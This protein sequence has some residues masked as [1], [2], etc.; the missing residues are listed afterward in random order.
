MHLDM[1]A[2]DH[3]H[4]PPRLPKDAANGTCPA[5][6]M[7]LSVLG[8][9]LRKQSL[10][11]FGPRADRTEA[12]E[13]TTPAAAAPQTHPPLATASGTQ[14][15]PAPSRRAST[16]SGTST[17][18]TKK[19]KR[20]KTIYKLAQPP[21]PRGKL[22]R[23]KVV[24]QLHQVVASRRPKPAFEVIPY[25]IFGPLSTRCKIRTYH[26]R[27][28]TTAD[29]VIL[30]AEEYHHNEDERSDEER[31][32]SREVV[33]VICPAKDDKGGVTKTAV[34]MENGQ[35]W[36][37]ARTPNGGYEFVHVD[38]H[39]LTLR[40]RWVAKPPH[41]RR[42]SSMS[43]ASQ[44]SPTEDRKFTFSTISQNSRRH[45]IIATMT[46][47]RIEVSD[48]YMMPSATSPSTPSAPSSALPTPLAT[49]SSID[50]NSFLDND[51][52]PIETDEALKAFIIA[53]GV[54]VAFQENWSPAYSILKG[55][56]PP[57]L[58]TSN[59]FRT[60]PNRTVSMTYVD[61]PRSASPCSMDESKRII[62]RIIRTHT[63][64]LH[65]KTS[66]P[67]SPVSSPIKTR[68]RRANSTGNTEI[69]RNSSLRKRFGLA[70]EDQ[71]VLET[72]EE[73][74][75]KRSMELL[76]VK[77]LALQPPPTFSSDN[78]ALSPIPSIEPPMSPTDPEPSPTLPDARTRKTRSAYDPVPT[79]GMWDSGVVEGKGTL[80]TRPTSLVVV[81]D[82]KMKAQRKE[83][84]SK[85]RDKNKEKKEKKEKDGRRKSEGLRGLFAG[86]F[87]KEK[88]VA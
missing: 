69:F 10:S 4:S 39:G 16:S 22:H 66:E 85:S 53:S 7:P 67:G 62:P 72:E 41:L 38:D 73:R 75:I 12:A 34:L 83:Q 26:G 31:F 60:T 58:A 5:L 76:R 29:L 2:A 17:E 28:L 57:P 52:L 51:R 44:A 18:K 48:S 61:S 8:S 1:L 78:G 74:H 37:V 63:Q 35:S 81:N 27:S 64:F 49:P 79:A 88:H 23:S 14:T 33:G 65:S 21:H 3:L 45:P 36:E 77:E 56:V 68:P 30:K 9:L 6:Q 71:P 20:P 46:R 11:P 25:T 40:S 32:G 55:G 50:M 87:H 15:S 43:N 54:W 84:R 24:L 13:A 80:R 42:Q 70:L 19:H 86:I 59:T 47:D 82:K